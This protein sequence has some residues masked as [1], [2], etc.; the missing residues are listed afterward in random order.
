MSGDDDRTATFGGGGHSPPVLPPLPPGTMLGDRY[1]IVSLIGRGGMGEVYRA[2]DLKIGEPVALK[3]FSS[4][5]SLGRLLAEVRIGRGVAHPNVCRLYDIGE[6]NGHHFITMEFVDGEDLASVLRRMGSLKHKKALAVIRE[7]CH[8]LSAAHE[9]GVIHRDLKPSNVMLDGRGTA[10]ITDFGLAA[11]SGEIAKNEICGTLNYMAPEQLAGGALTFRT[12]LYSLGLMMHELFTGKAVFDCDSVET[13]LTAHQ[14]KKPKPSAVAPDV[15]KTVERVI[16]A[17]VEEDPAKRPP[18]AQQ[19]L[20]LLPGVD[21]L[22]DALEEGKTP[23]VDIVKNAEVISTLSRRAAGIQFGA[24]VAGLITLIALAPLTMFYEHV[25]LNLSPEV[26]AEKAREVAATVRMATANHRQYAW[27]DWDVAYLKS[28]AGAKQSWRDL[29]SMSPGPMEY[30]S[31]WAEKNLFPRNP[32]GRIQCEA[33][34]LLSGLGRVVLDSAGRLKSVRPPGIPGTGLPAVSADCGSSFL[35]ALGLAPPWGGPMLIL[36]IALFVVVGAISIIRNKHRGLLDA[37]GGRKLALYIAA[38]STLAWACGADHSALPQN[39]WS[40]IV[41]GI[42]AALLSGGLVWLF[43]MALEP[44]VRAQRPLVLTAWQRLLSGWFNDPL[45]ARDVL[46]GICAGIVWNLWW[47]AIN[48]APRLWNLPGLVPYGGRFEAFTTIRGVAFRFFSVQNTAVLFGLGLVFILTSL[49]VLTKRMWLSFAGTGAAI[50]AI[51][52]PTLLQARP[53]HVWFVR[54]F[55]LGVAVGLLW[56]ATRFGV[57]ALIVATFIH[58]ELCAFPLT[59]DFNSWFVGRSILG[60]AF[61]ITLASWAA[62][63]SLESRRGV[64]A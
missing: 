26:L 15:D 4:E 41:T 40:M 32:T 50:F 7:I 39:E 63:A 54:V 61:I 45:I 12:D 52:Y 6:F 49:Q 31:Y 62:L 25:P 27:F 47:R 21:A 35:A 10:K 53:E 3:F 8:G 13:L 5:N 1:R 28:P 22:K 20:K 44:N 34:V 14:V 36:S 57:L 60:I 11:R 19:I 48:L 16:Q 42:S 58:F 18:S 38:V 59:S 33:P 17:C 9:K 24:I 55:S 43:Y 30:V 64:V 56:L 23:S 37:N 29:R 46:I 2:D 51:A